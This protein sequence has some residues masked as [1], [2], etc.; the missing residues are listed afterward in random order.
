MFRRPQ[1]QSVGV[2]FLMRTIE[3][4]TDGCPRRHVSPQE[5]VVGGDSAR[6]AYFRHLGRADATVRCLGVSYERVQAHLTSVGGRLRV[7]ERSGEGAFP[8]LAL[9]VACVEERPGA[10]RALIRR[11]EPA[12]LA[13]AGLMVDDAEARWMTSRLFQD[14]REATRRSH[15]RGPSLRR[16]RGEESLEEWL[17]ARLAGRLWVE[18]AMAP[19]AHSRGC[20]DLS[21]KRARRLVEQRRRVAAS[22]VNRR[23]WGRAV[24]GRCGA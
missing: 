2:S 3:D 4:A 24:A 15:G 1:R 8:D 17:S 9:A 22:Q 18:E 14:V 5:G 7:A 16:Y 21:V 23:T 13:F 19:V 10:W 20:A 6:L 11:Y 12:L